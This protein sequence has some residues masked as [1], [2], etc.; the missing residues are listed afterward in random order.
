MQMSI[1]IKSVTLKEMHE[2][3]T[4]YKRNVYLVIRIEHGNP[5]VLNWIFTVLGGAIRIANV[6]KETQ[7][8]VINDKG[9]VVFPESEIRNF[10][11]IGESIND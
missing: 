8:F 6:D 7:S 1:K 5:V 4:R 9:V 3:C 11:L 2:Y 10:E